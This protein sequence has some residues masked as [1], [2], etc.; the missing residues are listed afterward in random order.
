MSGIIGG[1]R[2]KSGIVG[3]E[4]NIMTQLFVY[5]SANTAVAAETSERIT[6]NNTQIDTRGEWTNY[7]WTCTIAGSYLI[8]MITTLDGIQATE[9][10]TSYIH[11]N[12]VG[13][14]A[15][16]GI[17]ASIDGTASVDTGGGSCAT[18]LVHC[19]VGDKIEGGCRNGDDDG[20]N[21]VQSEYATNMSISFIG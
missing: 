3:V 6:Y 19:V 15:Y 17:I 5:G 16:D 12:Q 18:R 8:S 14:G 4:T 10:C 21:F 1:T 2:S 9:R 7:Y 11:K 13:G 20:R